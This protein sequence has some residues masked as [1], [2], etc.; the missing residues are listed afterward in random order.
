MR[1]EKEQFEQKGTSEVIAQQDGLK[2]IVV[3]VALV[4]IAGLCYVVMQSDFLRIMPGFP[5]GAYPPHPA[6]SIFIVVLLINGISRIVRRRQLIKSSS[7]VVLYNMLIVAFTVITNGFFLPVVFTMGSIQLHARQNAKVF[8]SILD[9]IPRWVLPKDDN[10]VMGFWI[11]NKTGQVPW[12]NWIL[13]ITMMCVFFLLMYWVMLSLINLVY[14][15][16][17]EIDHMRYP[18]AYAFVSLIDSDE[19]SD[20]ATS[21]TNATGV[22]HNRLMWVGAI[23]AF[24]IAISQGLK[25]YFPMMPAVPTSWHASRL[26]GLAEMS[27]FARWALIGHPGVTLNM[28]PMFIGIGYLIV[29]YQLSLSIGFFNLLFVIWRGFVATIWGDLGPRSAY[30]YPVELTTGAFIALFV[31][32]LWTARFQIRD[33]IRKALSGEEDAHAPLSYRTSLLG[34]TMGFILLVIFAKIGLN[35]DIWASIPY[36]ALMFIAALVMGRVR[37][38]AGVPQDT[39]LG[40]PPSEYLGALYGGIRFGTANVA[41]FAFTDLAVGN[42]AF[43]SLLPASMDAYKMADSVGM[44]KRS[45]TYALVIA[46]I[47]A[48]VFSFVIGLPIIYKKGAMLTNAWYVTADRDMVGFAPYVKDLFPTTSPGRFVATVAGLVITMLFRYA[49]VTFTWFPFHPLGILLA[50]HPYHFSYVA[51]F[52][53]SGVI[54]WIVIRYGGNVTAKK[55]E[56]FFIGLI[57]GWVAGK[58]LFSLTGI[59]LSATGITITL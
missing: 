24:L 2:W 14:K 16:W 40:Y 19:R 9:A 12:G 17:T 10:A 11:G 18:L 8:Q 45:M 41:G 6:V 20:I 32:L 59:V 39:T 52:L 44:R 36:F 22:L 57:L 37:A 26:P 25:T 23:V 31:S 43:G 3:L 30:H 51:P 53:V 1:P 15:Q 46:I 4:L 55:L 5:I 34:L 27:V 35:I 58:T 47:A 56:P 21:K 13:P 50:V 49:H 42:G 38:D 48:M 33:V 54:K 29:G 7:L 28:D